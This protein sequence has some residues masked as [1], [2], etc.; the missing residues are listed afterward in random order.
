M[1]EN[2]LA[3]R[4]WSAF[5]KNKME[6]EMKRTADIEKAFQTIRAAT[7]LS[8]V[9]DIVNRFLTREQTYSQLLAQVADNEDKIDRLREA[10]EEWRNNLHDLQIKNSGGM[11]IERRSRA[12]NPDLYQL[13]LDI[14]QAEREKEKIEAVNGKVQLVNEQVEAWCQRISE[15]IDQQFNENIISYQDKTMA[16]TFSK[17]TQAVSKQLEV[18]LMEEEDNVLG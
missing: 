10:N 3:Q 17:I 8:D 14:V 16:F 13:D 9:Q 5:L 18:I 4:F 6:K 7:G 1:Q 11:E 2:Y 12:Q 15:K